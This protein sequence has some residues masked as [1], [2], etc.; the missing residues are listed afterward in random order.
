MEDVGRHFCRIGDERSPI[1]AAESTIGD[2]ASG[3][4]L[5][6][7]LGGIRNTCFATRELS[8]F[9]R[10]GVHSNPSRFSWWFRSGVSILKLLDADTTSSNI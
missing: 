9:N 7:V 4:L 10:D 5:T 6:D 2:C 3:D 8:Q 1:F